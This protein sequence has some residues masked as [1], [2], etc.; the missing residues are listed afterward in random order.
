MLQVS[1]NRA[2]SSYALA[3]GEAAAYRLRILH[4]LYAPGTG[5]ALLDA[6]LQQGMRVADVGCGVG[7][8]TAL[9]AK[10]V[11]PEGSVVGID[12]SGEQLLHAREQLDG[13][14]A[15]VTFVQA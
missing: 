9:L 4:E 3:A 14:G 8:V 13:D 11:G 10:L 5:R 1:S 6:G 15:N 2:D 7:T 12:A